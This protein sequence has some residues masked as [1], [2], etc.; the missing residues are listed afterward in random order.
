MKRMFLA[1]PFK[2][3]VNPATGRMSDKDIK[4]FEDIILYFEN[5]D[6]EVHS[7]HRREKW[8]Q[9]FMTPDECTKKDYEE[10]SRCDIF[11]AFPGSP[12]SPGTH[13]EMGWASALGKPVILLLEKEGQ[14]AFLVQ[15]LN[16]V[17]N[18]TSISYSDYDLNPRWIEEAIEDYT[19]RF[20]S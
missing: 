17:G 11:V 15:G 5:K 9:E 19:E 12:A 14:Y 2:L 4:L 18:T 8:G 1:G 3:L 20:Q 10:I 16:Q 13:I 6:W 7:A